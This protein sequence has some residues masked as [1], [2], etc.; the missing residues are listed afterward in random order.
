MMKSITPLELHSKIS[1]KDIFILIDVRTSAEREQYN[2]GGLH[3]PLEEIL[4][5]VNQ[6]DLGKEVVFYCEKGIRSMIAIQRLENK[7]NDNQ[8]YNLKGGME[9]WK[10]QFNESE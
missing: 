4:Q 7:F 1:N 9:A 5:H 2:I 8:L 3:F 10:K 6:I